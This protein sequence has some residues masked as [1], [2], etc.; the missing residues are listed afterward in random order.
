MDNY[1]ELYEEIDLMQ[2]TYATLFSLANKI[3]VKGDKYLET[4]TI[5]DN[6]SNCSFARR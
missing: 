6:G 2:Q 4:L 5:Y 1:K 3:Q